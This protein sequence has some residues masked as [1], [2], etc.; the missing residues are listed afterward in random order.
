MVDE[1]EKILSVMFIQYLGDVFRVG[2][3]QESYILDA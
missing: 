3:E 1:G 2:I